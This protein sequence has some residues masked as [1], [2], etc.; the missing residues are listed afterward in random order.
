MFLIYENDSI[1]RKIEEVKLVSLRA[2]DILM[3]AKFSQNK[4]FDWITFCFGQV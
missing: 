2:L 1:R 3:P 4:V